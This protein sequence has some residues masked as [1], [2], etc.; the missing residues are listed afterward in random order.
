MV[1]G[2]WSKDAGASLVYKFASGQTMHLFRDQFSNTWFELD[3]DLYLHT[4]ANLN[5][6]R[7]ELTRRAEG[8]AAQQV[9]H[10]NPPGVSDDDRLKK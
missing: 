4:E 3:T 2:D 8:F 1:C 9:P 10:V 7:E 5:A 6:A